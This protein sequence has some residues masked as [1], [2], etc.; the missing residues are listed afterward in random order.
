MVV[1]PHTACGTAAARFL[2]AGVPV[3]AHAQ[4][5]PAKFPEAVAS[6]IGRR[7]PLP[8]ALARAMEA[9]ERFAVLPN[10]LA[11]VQAFIASEAGEGTGAQDAAPP[12]GV[13]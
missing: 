5:H 12:R 2:E 10:D 6:A 3:V 1:D 4:A 11:A 8:E 7:P 13:P 9:K